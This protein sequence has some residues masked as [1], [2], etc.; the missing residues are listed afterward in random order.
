MSGTTSP[1]CALC[2]SRARTPFRAPTPELAPDLDMRPG[3]PAWETVQDWLQTCDRCGA[4]APDLAA[5][6]ETAKAVVQSA[7]YR[8]LA[9]EK[10]EETLPFRRWALLCRAAGDSQA[11]T[12][13]MLMAAWAADDAVSMLE[14]S[15]L[16]LTVAEAWGETED[17]ATAL[18]RLDVL[19]RSSHFAAADAWANTLAARPLDRAGKA[20]LAF[21][22]DRIAQRDIG[23]HLVTSALP[24]GVEHETLKRP[25]FWSWLFRE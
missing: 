19:R 20:I 7:A 1:R 22:R 9:D 21:Q 25:G 6:P 11:A 4:V 12:E 10:S 14:A 13:A 18:W 3:E 2:G 15:R 24:P 16:R 23:R 17:Q 8:D 5:L